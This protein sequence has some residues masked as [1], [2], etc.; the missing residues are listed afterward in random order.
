MTT[1]TVGG[2]TLRDGTTAVD[3]ANGCRWVLGA[4]DGWWAGLGIR[5]AP[6]DNP[7]LD[8]AFD[9]PSP[10]SARTVGV[11]GTVLAP[12]SSSLTRALDLLA[13][14]LAGPRRSDDLVVTD[15]AG[16]RTSVVRLGGPTML[17]RTGPVAATFSLSLFAADPRRYG[18]T[19]STLTLKRFLAGGGRAYPF[20]PPRV[21]GGA[22]GFSGTGL[23]NNSGN[24][25][26]WPLITFTG[27]ITNPSLILDDG[28][29][30]AVTITLDS[31]QSLVIDTAKRT[32]YLG[33]SSRRSSINATTRWFEIGANSYRTVQFQADAGTG[34]ATV[35][36][37]AAWS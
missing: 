7:M 27:P 1:L 29:V 26:T 30:I 6:I 19:W 15:S 25:D 16:S 22:S 9:G 10:F 34:T 32:A 31:T 17:V 2:L 12:D 4:L 13:G 8:G 11:T 37:R 33:T 18:T 21:Y 36:Y 20:H 35:Q 23:V 5:S 14:L 3:P 28:R 24:A